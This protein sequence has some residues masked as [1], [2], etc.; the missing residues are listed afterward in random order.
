MITPKGKNGEVDVTVKLAG[1]N[2]KVLD[3]AQITNPVSYFYTKMASLEV[4]FSP[5]TH[6]TQKAHKFRPHFPLQK[7][8][9]NTFLNPPTQKAFLI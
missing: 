5:P 4:T 1:Y 2:Q 8:S 9:S 7:P 6:P 3:A